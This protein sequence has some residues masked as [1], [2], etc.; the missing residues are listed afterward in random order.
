MISY[1]DFKTRAGIAIYNL[2]GSEIFSSIITSDI[3]TV[4]MSKYPSGVYFV[5]I[6]VPDEGA[7]VKKKILKL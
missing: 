5:I 3:T 6:N 1:P 2:N 4:D 7:V